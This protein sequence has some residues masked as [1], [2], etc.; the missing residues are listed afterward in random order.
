MTVPAVD[1]ALVEGAGGVVWSV[2][3]TGLH[4]NLV[5]LEPGGSIVGHRNDAV[6]VLVIAL[7][8][9]GTLTVDEVPVALAPSI[10]ALVPLGVRRAVTAGPDGLRYLTIHAARGPLS[11]GPPGQRRV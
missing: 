4:T 8:G 1:L 7:A 11:I 2:S 6:D 9:G 10:A 3:P 5:V